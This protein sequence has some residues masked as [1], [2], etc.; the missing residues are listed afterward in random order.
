V[1]PCGPVV[2]W[3]FEGTYCLHLQVWKHAKQAMSS[4]GVNIQALLTLVSNINFFLHQIRNIN[5][6]LHLFWWDS[7]NQTL[8]CVTLTRVSTHFYCISIHVEIK[9]NIGVFLIINTSSAPAICLHS[10]SQG[11]LWVFFFFQ[12][13]LCW[14]WT[15]SYHIHQDCESEWL[16]WT[17]F[18]ANYLRN[19]CLITFSNLLS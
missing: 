2:H 13:I 14:T 16:L 9:Q 17:Y 12:R 6:P 11:K 18:K 7:R 10:L 4:A 1:T 19:T 8:L 3:C 5:W 15:A